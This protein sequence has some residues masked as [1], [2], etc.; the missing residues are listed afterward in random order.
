MNLRNEGS[1]ELVPPRSTSSAASSEP[2][3]SDPTSAG[4]DPEAVAEFIERFAGILYESGVP[5]M[6]ARVFVALLASDSGRLTA[7][8]LG[9][10]LRVSPAAVSGAVRYLLQVG[11]VSGAGEPGS[12]R[13]SYSVPDDIWQHLLRLRNATMTRWADVLRDGADLLGTDSPAGERVAESARYFEFVATELP[14][15]LARWDEFKART[16][17]PA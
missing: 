9:A 4:R 5:R 1:G 3:G 7:A 12:R 6:P 11:L 13:L 8:D 2:T 14:A 15:V 17:R 10:S 16:G